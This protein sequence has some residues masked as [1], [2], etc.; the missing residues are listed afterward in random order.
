MTPE[1]GFIKAEDVVSSMLAK[2]YIL[3]QDVLN[4]AK[5]FDEKHQLTSAATSKVASLDQKVGLSEKISAG[6]ILVNDKVKEMDEKFQVS[7]KTKS[8]FSAAEQSLSNAG[9]TIMK[10]RYVLTGATWVTGAYNRVAKAAGE[11]GQKAREKALAQE[12]QEKTEDNV[13]TIMP[14][15]QH[16][17]TTANQP[18]EHES[19]HAAKAGQPSNPA[20]TQGLV[21]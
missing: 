17:S 2:G 10:N 20:T 13:H 18:S 11:V 8:A 14:E 5:V 15:S 19:Q 7:E 9:S 1:S 6:T 4:R 12:N 16:A 3:G 21:L